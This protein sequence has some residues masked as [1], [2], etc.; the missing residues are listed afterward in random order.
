MNVSDIQNARKALGTRLAPTRL[1]F[2]PE[3]SEVSGAEV[4]L[5]LENENATGSFKPRGALHTM[6]CRVQRGPLP[7]VVTSSTGNHGAAVA[8]A[9]RQLGVPAVIFL[10]ENPNQVK[11]A[12]IA[13][14]GA[15]I[16]EAGAFLED[17]RR[18]AAKYAAEHGWHLIIDGQDDDLAAGAGTIGLE[19]VEQLEAVDTILVPV[20][21][22]SL[23]RGLACGAK[24]LKKN[25]RIVGIVAER[26]PAYY[27][28]WNQRKTVCT[29]RSDTIAD[30]L[31]V[32][33]AVDKTVAEMLALVNA[34][35][36]VSEEEMLRAMKRLILDAKV[37]AEPSGA[38]TTAA[39]LKSGKEWA[40][41]KIVLVVSGSNVGEELLRRALQMP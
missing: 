15:R 4:F 9:A 8:Y 35:K 6:L 27:L 18:H 38:A 13:R 33:D 17:S 3:L 16:V 1:I 32:R 26:A 31:A 7:G 2:S 37:V 21:D 12:R 28:S 11:R 20:G 10:P 36:M 22:G 40:G 29:D 14:E 39:L 30:G 5:K 24:G 41:R 23:I 25:V 34:M 19:I